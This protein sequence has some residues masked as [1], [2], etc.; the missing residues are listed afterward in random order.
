MRVFPGLR[1]VVA[2]F[3]LAAWL[4]GVPVSS[5]AT[6]SAAGD[7]SAIS[8]P[9]GP[10]SYGMTAT[11]GGAFTPLLPATWPGS[12]GAL[13]GWSKSGGTIDDFANDM[14]AV[15]ANLTAGPVSPTPFVTVG[16]GQLLL[17]PGFL[18]EYAVVRWT[19]PAAGDYSVSAAYTGLDSFSDQQ[20]STDVHVLLNGVSI[21][22]GEVDTFGPPPVEFGSLLQD[23]AAGATLDFVVGVGPDGEFFNDS[24]RLEALISTVPLPATLALLLVALGGAAMARRR[25][26]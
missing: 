11:L 8:N 10:W 14:P 12:G 1:C 4:A 26:V 3:L 9:N 24:T 22:D 2:V 16:P 15:V 17:H 13:S 25:G 18:G 7:F 21:F 23:L 19:A 5:A 20:H 6:F